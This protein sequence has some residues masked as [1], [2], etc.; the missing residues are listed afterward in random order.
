MIIDT[1]KTVSELIQLYLKRMGKG[2]LFNN[3]DGIC[4]VFNANKIPFDSPIKVGDFFWF[5]SYPNIIVNDYS[6]VI[7]KDEK[8]SKEKASLSTPACFTCEILI[9]CF[10][11]I[12]VLV[13]LYYL[14]GD[15]FKFMK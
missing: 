3:R 4:F 6:F 14:I 11:F 12:S 13:V 8:Y 10:L 5:N 9:I 1:S 7:L 15:R 2:E